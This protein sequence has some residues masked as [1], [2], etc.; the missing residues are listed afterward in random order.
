MMVEP[1]DP[2]APSP[3]AFPQPGWRG[4]ADGRCIWIAPWW[5]ALTG[6]DASLSL[7]RGWIEHIHPDDRAAL[8]TMWRGAQAEGSGV[9]DLRVTLAGTRGYRWLRIQTMREEHD[10]VATWIASAVDI[11]DLRRRLDRERT[12]RLALQHRV[13]NTLSV[14][15]SVARRTAETSE[16]VDDY[17]ARFDGRLAAF[18]R[19]QGHILRGDE[20]GTDLEALLADE[21]LANQAGYRN[22]VSYGGPEVRL[23]PRL[24]DQLG[25]AL[26]ELVANAVQFGALAREGG[27]IAIHWSLD[28]QGDALRLRLVWDEDVPGGGITPPAG[29]G[30]GLELLTRSLHYEIDATVM[31]DFRPGGL[32]CAMEIPLPTAPGSAARI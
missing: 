4:T 30:F 8:T 22:R 13:R 11:D 6:Q 28:A 26:H 3:L 9:V 16:T 1:V 27:R 15:R 17:R 20:Q 5:H 25:L 24:T 18:A 19:A 31:L 10:G 2:A 12:R 21:L 23:P 32:L 7:D 29:E 14:I